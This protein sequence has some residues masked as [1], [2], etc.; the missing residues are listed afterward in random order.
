MLK[1]SFIS[2]T[3]F[4]GISFISTAQVSE[5]CNCNI[6]TLGYA[7]FLQTLTPDENAIFQ[8]HASGTFA[9]AYGVIGSTTPTV[10]QNLID[11]NPLVTT[12]IL[13]SCPGSEDDDSNLVASMLI[14]NQGYKMYLPDNGF[15]SSG[16]VD[17]FL[18]GSVRVI[19]ATY[20][21]VGVHSW[22]DGTNDATFFPV[23][24]PNHQP[25][26]DYY[27]NIGFT[28]Q[29]SEDFYYFTINAANANGIYWMTQ[30]EIDQYKIRSCRYS[31]NPNYTITNLNGVLTADLA[32]ASYQWLDCDN[33]YDI[34]NGAINQSFTPTADGNFAIQITETGCMD[35]S[36]CTTYSTTGINDFIINPFDFS[37]YPN[38]SKN[39]FNISLNKVYSK[40]SLKLIDLNGITLIKTE[41]FN[42]KNIFLSPNLPKGVYL[43]KIETNSNISTKQIIIQ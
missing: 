29:E 6:D 32:S 24:H 11:N 28:L 17:M 23:G 42:S 20:D 18:A 13:H 30:A 22:S 10:V 16:A 25:Y 37:I 12:I 27:V 5:S 33:N 7:N 2:L 36:N 43:L 31:A 21:P 38:P 4:V 1:K 8:L 26:I 3:F 34:I 39:E 40:I 15:I 14:Y 41:F 35:T 9:V 19:D